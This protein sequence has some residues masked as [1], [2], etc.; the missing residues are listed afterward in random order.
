MTVEILGRRNG[1]W[2][3][4]KSN[5]APLYKIAREE[6]SAIKD[7][8]YA[9]RIQIITGPRR[10]GKST[11]MQQAAAYLLESG[12]DPKRILFLSADDPTV[13]DGKSSIGDI[14]EFYAT[15]VLHEAIPSLTKRVFFFIDE[16]HMQDGWQL[17][18]KNYYEPQYNVKFVI[19]GASLSHLFDGARESLLGRTDALRLMPLGFIQFCKFLSVYKGGE[20][21]SEFI[22]TIPRCSLYEDPDAYYE[23]LA[24]DPWRWEQFKPYAV[25]ALNEFLLIGGYPEYF[26]DASA[27]LWQKRLVE[28]IIGQGL[29]RDIVGV[30]KVK[31]PD[32]LEKLL[33]FI[34]GN[35]GKSFSVKAIADSIGCDNE[36][37]G[38]Y[39][40]Y[41]TQ[42]YMT[43]VLQNYTPNTSKALRQDKTLFVLDN[44]IANAMLRLPD[45]D[46]ARAAHIVESVC[47]RDALAACEKNLW[48]LFYW[49]EK[50]YEVDLVIDRK[51]DA[52]PI[53]VLY[54]AVPSGGSLAAFRKTF[55]YLKAPV[56]VVITKD[57]L[58]RERD[59][60]FV[61]FWLAR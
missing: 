22:E 19:S 31:T 50:D 39:L 54:N 10:A 61:P 8:L 18:L 47:A 57:R 13:F 38:A 30:H 17:W 42:A 52:L 23:E 43:I 12:V 53:E 6:L 20:K 41:L 36:T 46:E 48:K 16:I 21:I 44:G 5:F 59:A 51:T 60:L 4:G 29:Y 14:L 11:L 27:A 33:Y 15:N 9:R 24:Y 40:S 55:Y 58:A 2:S 37:V 45:V 28:D 7:N 35:Y 49:K 3:S 32:K 25:A 1:W 34:A 26:S 56:S